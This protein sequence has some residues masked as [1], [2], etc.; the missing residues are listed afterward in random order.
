VS[1][2]EAPS[3]ERLARELE[4]LER[5]TTQWE[6]QQRATL[7]A[8][9]STQ[10]SLQGEALRR[11]IKALKDDPQAKPALLRAVDDEW[12]RALLGY[13]GILRTPTGPA[14]L[15]ERLQAALVKLR[16]GLQQHG[17]DVEL[18]ALEPPEVSL[19]L[20]G[21]CD[22]CAFAGTSTKE[23]IESEIKRACPELQ[24]VRFTHGGNTLVPLRTPRKAHDVCAVDEVPEGGALFREAQGVSLLLTRVGEE[25]R[26]F[27]NACPHLGMP[28]DDA[29]IKGGIITCRYHGFRYA[30]ADGEC[31][32]APEIALARLP[33]SQQ[34]G[35]V[36]VDVGPSALRGTG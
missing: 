28:L 21:S 30:L 24:Q 20:V 3:L 14:P 9:R 23:Q 7:E 5:I 6:T 27:P 4:R 26:A 33:V 11:L 16:P 29:E 17:G 18:V 2:A 35:R 10:D 34:A 1:E 13:H 12:V 25:V 8:I 22:G 32:T 19:R 31:L 15:A 36:L